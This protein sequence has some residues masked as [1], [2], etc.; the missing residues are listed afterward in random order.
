MDTHEHDESAN[1]GPPSRSQIVGAVFGG[2]AAALGFATLFEHA[3]MINLGID[4]FLVKRTWG[5]NAA[6]SLMRMGPP[7]SVSFA[8]LGS[9]IC[10]L[11]LGGKMSRRVASAIAM[12]C[13]AIA[14]LSLIGYFYGVNQLFSMPKLTGIARQAA[15]A[16]FAIGIGVVTL[17]PEWGFA[18]LMSR[19]DGG[20]VL[21]RRVLPALIVAAILV[22]WLRLQGQEANLYDTAFGTALRTLVE[23][24]LLLVLV[25]WTANSLSQ[26]E[27]NLRQSRE[28]LRRA[29][30]EANSAG[31]LKDEFLATLSHELRNPMTAILGWSGLVR[32]KVDRKQDVELAHG[33]EVIE[34]NAKIQ[35][36]M[37]DDLLDLS[38]IASGKVKLNIQLVEL[39]EVVRSAVDVVK[40][41]A[42]AKGVSI[43]AFFGTNIP[44]IRADSTR[45][46]QALFNLLV[47]A[48]KFTPSGGRVHI[49]CARAGP[50]VSI[51]VSDTGIGIEPE[52]LPEPERHA[53][54]CGG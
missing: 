10:M 28:E 51:A 42:E 19:R 48:V 49:E 45:L 47:N 23:M 3:T 11:A 27:T 17:V 25:W 32:A 26:T 16:I 43:Q 1:D 54:S 38:R 53:D 6:A 8:A 4:T 5:Q 9:S 30:N 40:P 20:G 50:S 41:G 13:V 37:I 44:Q 33:L 36:Q 24:G 12:M 46:Q 35:A 15:T 31:R 34:R 14:S 39:R 2:L 22:G 18:H 21:A 7:A 52:F 29:L